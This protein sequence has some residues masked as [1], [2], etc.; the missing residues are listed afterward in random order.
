[1]FGLETWGDDRSKLIPAKKPTRCMTNARALGMELNRKCDRGH[2]HQSLVDGRAA[3]AGRYPDD[4]CR[5]ICKG[6]IKEK[7][8]RSRGI[9]AV[10]EIDRKLLSRFGPPARCNGTRKIG[11]RSFMREPRLRS[12]PCDL[13]DWF[14]ENQISAVHQTRWHGTISRG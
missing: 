8:E 4:L 5:A 3:S 2:D 14:R 11:L 10:G 13:G 9:R 6:I 1:M 7:M 12:D